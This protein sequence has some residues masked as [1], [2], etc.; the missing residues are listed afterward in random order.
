MYKIYK[1]LGHGNLGP[2]TFRARH[3]ASE[4]HATARGLQLPI[5]SIDQRGQQPIAAQ[6]VLD[7]YGKPNETAEA[8]L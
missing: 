8:S 3:N 1:S 4:S 5:C 6:Q 2:L 7:G